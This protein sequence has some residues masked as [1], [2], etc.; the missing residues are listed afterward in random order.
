LEFAEFPLAR[1]VGSNG[2]G[3]T[4]AGGGLRA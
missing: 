4:V 1:L 2:H 3:A